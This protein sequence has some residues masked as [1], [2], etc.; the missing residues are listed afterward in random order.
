MEILRRAGARKAIGNERMI[1]AWP[2]RGGP[3]VSDDR[4]YFA[5]SIW[6]FMGTYIWCLD[7]CQR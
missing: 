4:V 6:P 2:A 7:A 3:V 1:S 5:T